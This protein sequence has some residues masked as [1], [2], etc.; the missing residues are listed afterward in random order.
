[1]SHIIGQTLSKYYGRG[2]AAVTAITGMDFKIQS[3]EFVAIMG[4]SGAGKSTLLSIMG[5][6][7][8]PSEGTLSVEG[9]DVYSLDAERRADF[10]REFLGFIFQ[11]FHLIP[12]LDLEE[13]VMLPLATI[14]TSRRRKRTMARDALAAVGLEGK[15]RRLPSQISGGEKERTA[16][17]RA[18][19]NRPPV[20]LAD[21]PTGNLDSKTSG[22]IM[23]LLQEL[24]AKGST[25]VM[26]THSRECARYA[27]RIMRVADGRLAQAA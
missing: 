17:A 7:N 3:G 19:V 18:I 12:Y 2:D 15:Q 20:I 14:R 9:I 26:V 1:M 6:M 27:D 10:R 25:I 21:E 16:I 13:N 5:A 23:S 11:S 8:A 24:N 22:E 4:E